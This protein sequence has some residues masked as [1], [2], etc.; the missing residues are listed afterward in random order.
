MAAWSLRHGKPT[1][2]PPSFPPLKPANSLQEN[3]QAIAENMAA[4]CYIK[5]IHVKATTS[6]TLG[7]K[8]AG[9]DAKDE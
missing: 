2:W 6:G 1:S 3:K 9:R 8:A 4:Q 5:Y 7:K